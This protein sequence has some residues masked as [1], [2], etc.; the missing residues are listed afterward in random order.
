MVHDSEEKTRSRATINSLSLSKLE[1]QMT[2]STGVAPYGL[3]N[4]ACTNLGSDIYVFGGRCDQRQMC[5]THNDL[6]VFST[7]AN[8]WS[9]V[10]CT[11]GPMNKYSCGFVTLG[12]TDHLQS[13]HSFLLVLGGRGKPLNPLPLHS[14]YIPFEEE[15]FFTNEVHF[16]DIKSLGTNMSH[17]HSL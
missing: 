15:E 13:T 7:V 9:H 10:P 14:T 5:C 1:W 4:Y 2:Q 3:M 17:H 6:H 11:E 16:M 12:S 8:T